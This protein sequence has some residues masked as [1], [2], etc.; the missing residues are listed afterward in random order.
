[1][2]VMRWTQMRS[3]LALSLGFALTLATS[4]CASDTDS[5]DTAETESEFEGPT[6]GA[7]GIRCG[8]PVDRPHDPMKIEWSYHDD[9]DGPAKWGD[10]T[11]DTTC[12][13]G[14]RRLPSTS[15]TRSR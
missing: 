6:D 12:G 13:A 9:A 10:L 1:M 7:G 11:T 5:L 8:A 4:G 15:S 3:R 14:W 2:N